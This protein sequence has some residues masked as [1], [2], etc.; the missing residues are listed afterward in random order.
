MK[1]SASPR[2]WANIPVCSS[3]Q[4][5]IL[6]PNLWCPH[7]GGYVAIKPL[8][9]STPKSNLGT[10][11][12]FSPYLPRFETEVSLS[13]GAT[14]IAVVKNLG[15]LKGLRLKLENRNPTGTFRDRGSSLLVSH[16]LS[17]KMSKI[18]SVSTGSYGIS[19]AAYC[20]QANLE[21]V[22]IV[23]QNTELSK[24]EQLRVFGSKLVQRG[25]N[26]REAKKYA[27]KMETDDSTYMPAP[28]ENILTIEAQKTIALEIIAK[29]GKIIDNIIVPQGSGSLTMSMF[30]GIEDALES[31]WIEKAPRI[32]PVSLKEDAEMS[33][34][35]E[36]LEIDD[37]EKKLLEEVNARI[38]KTGALRVRVDPKDMIDDALELAK[39][40][41]HFVEPASASVLSA[42]KY[43]IADNS[44]DPRRS[45]AILSGSGLN[46]LNVFAS[47]MRRMKKVVWGVTSTS[48]RKFEILNLIAEDKANNGSEIWKALGKKK[49]RQSIYQHLGMLEE[50]GL[51]KSEMKTKK[52]KKYTLTRKGFEALDKMRELIDLL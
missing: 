10:M 13:E 7:C 12:D 32:I 35:I 9:A 34:L 50:K 29:C 5:E 15:H 37:Q 19:L 25:E 38:E 30:R 17:L 4:E 39:K 48:T 8:K 23:P 36:S 22:N 47:K 33:Y 52:A 18:R 6:I 20:A 21:S 1:I 42:V 28:K 41:G 46:A 16:A 27:E 11:W 40:E 43:L 51:I 14:P 26:V 31:Q 24:V 2:F 49:S 3:C 44:I 45:V